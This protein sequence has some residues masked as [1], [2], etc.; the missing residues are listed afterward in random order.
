[1]ST[2]LTN[3]TEVKSHDGTIIHSINQ[4]IFQRLLP[5]TIL[6]GTEAL[7][8][9][10]GNVLILCVY[11][12][13]YRQCNFRYFVLFLALYDL[14]S[15]LTALPGEM[16]LQL[17]W[18]NFRY[19]SIC[20]IKSFFNVFTAWG[21]A[22]TLSLLACDRYRKVCKPL[23]SQ[24][25]PSRALKLCV[26]GVIL[27]FIVSIPDA[28][29]WGKQ[30][31]SYRY[32]E[33]NYTLNLSICEKANE[34]KDEIYPFAYIVAVYILPLG[35][36]SLVICTVNVMIAREMFC[37]KRKMKLNRCHRNSNLPTKSANVF[38]IS[39][40]VQTSVYKASTRNMR[41]SST[42][43][44]NDVRVIKRDFTILCSTVSLD[45]LSIESTVTSSPGGCDSLPSV[46]VRE[47]KLEE[48]ANSSNKDLH[49]SNRGDMSD[50]TGVT[51]AA[52]RVTSAA[53]GVTSA[54]RGV[55]SAAR[56]RFRT[57]TQ[58]SADTDVRMRKK[59]LIML[60]LTSVF[61]LTITIYIA[62][63]TVVAKSSGQLDVMRQL[64]NPDIV[65]F[66]F[67]LRLYY[68]NVVINLLL[69][70]L[71]DLRFRTGLRRL[72]CRFKG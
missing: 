19:D 58:T 56:N 38:N 1:M 32:I 68:V 47:D 9:L 45:S 30:S 64:E 40:R 16:Y 63:I 44:G 15:C 18:F 3:V 48:N 5:I 43:L 41:Q 35:V 24:M 2:K 23:S 28:V 57:I 31:F 52:R 21:S 61:V 46:A 72:L 27:S 34:Y 22:F 54:A 69:Y 11:S 6:T 37:K 51:S 66:L 67:F 59:T 29:L 12:R 36:I 8:G 49:E 33:G 60:I 65:L 50:A 53:R 62:L 7:V 17:N 14:T 10:V 26:T 70:G 39:R 71:L 13:F 55:T 4:R 42:N 20:K 25:R